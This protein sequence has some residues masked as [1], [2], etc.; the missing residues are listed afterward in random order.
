MMSS[1]IF[2]GERL[3]GPILGANDD[4]TPTSL[5]ILCAWG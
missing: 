5:P 4:A 3:S 2:F 1:P